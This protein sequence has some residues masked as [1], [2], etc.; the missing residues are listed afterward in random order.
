MRRWVAFV[1]T[2]VPLTCGQGTSPCS[3][4]S[5]V[6]PN[7]A[8]LV[9]FTR[10]NTWK[11]GR[12]ESA[13]TGTNSE[14]MLSA[15]RHEFEPVQVVIAPNTGSMTP[16]LTV[17][18]WPGAR[19]DMA[20]ATF[21]DGTTDGLDPL[22]SGSPVPLSST[23]NTVLWLTF[24]IP[25]DAS[26]PR[27]AYTHLLTLDG[28]PGGA[29]NIPISMYV[30]DFT[31]PQD[32]HYKTHMNVGGISGLSPN[33]DEDE[34]KDILHDHRWT[35]KAPA[36]PDPAPLPSGG[37]TW[38]SGF[39]W[40]ITWDTATNPNQCTAFYDEQDQGAAYSISELAKKYL[41]GTG[42]GGNKF[43][44]HQG[45]GF[46][47]NSQTLPTT[48][49]G[50]ALEGTAQVVTRL[51]QRRTRQRALLDQALPPGHPWDQYPPAAYQTKW[52]AYL[53]EL[54]SYLSANGYLDQVYYYT[55]N[56]PQHGGTENDEAAFL[57]NMAKSAA[58]NLKIMV[59]DEAKPEIAENV[60]QG[61][62]GYDIWIPHQLSMMAGNNLAYANQRCLPP[63]CPTHAHAWAFVPQRTSNASFAVSYKDFGEETW[64]YPLPQDTDPYPNPEQKE[65][66]SKNAPG[67]HARIYPWISWAM[68]VT[69]FG[70]Y[71]A[72]AWWTGSKPDITAELFR[73]GFE[74]WE[75]MWLANG[76][77]GP[78][79]GVT[80]PVDTTV[81]S[82]AKDLMFWFRED[83]PIACLRHDLGLYIE[84]TLTSP[85]EVQVDPG[86]LEL[87]CHYISFQ[88]PAGEPTADP[89]VEDGHE[90]TKIGANL[91]RYKVANGEYEVTVCVGHPDREYPNDLHNVWV[92]GN[93]IVDNYDTS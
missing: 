82:V 15:A 59:S 43:P 69:G 80:G 33:N 89:L 22:A 92:E 30:F 37:A 13:P 27:G 67:L 47:S 31:L 57:C 62:C 87:T 77:K 66:L 83:D 64:I 63:A 20:V 41:G 8:D 32:I 54:E 78:E 11:V 72:G 84:G 60:A 79:V 36:T 50:E 25:D 48:F 76:G 26:V 29:I 23:D 10:P 56:E 6:I 58:P 52:K 38:P 4:G 53:S 88:D 81:R 73:E 5:Y 34:A 16:I 74:D 68:R 44:V 14:L 86:Q 91:F 9:V 28:R 75:Y 7:T 21:Y 24:Y 93:H 18:T 1:T 12:T 85:P 65:L 70:Y 17:P 42:W 71:N 45:L 3:G 49:C 90:W 35:A 55:M 40:A 19:A 2:T 39:G 61:A 51:S 46:I